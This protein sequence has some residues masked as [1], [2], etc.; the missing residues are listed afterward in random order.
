MSTNGV[1][2]DRLP[3]L[4]ELREQLNAHYR[5]GAAVPRRHAGLAPA[6]R[7]RPLALI[8][9]LILGGATGALAAAGVFQAPAVI[10]RYDRSVTPVVLRAINGSRCARRHFPATT[11]ST[12]PA[13]LLATLRVLRRPSRRG[14]T[15]DVLPSLIMPGTSL[16]VRYVRLARSVD[17]FDFYVS[18]RT[19]FAGTPLNIGRCMAAMTANFTRE[20]PRLPRAFRAEATHIFDAALG[21][22]RADWLR[23]P[24]PFVGVGLSA[25]SIYA[26]GNGFGG[27][28]STIA[29]IDEGKD[30]G[31][32]GGATGSGANTSFVDGLVPDGVS[33]L[34]LHYD[35]GP[36]GGYSRQHVPALN[37]TTRVV[38]NV[39]A[40]IVPR[41]TGNAL[42]WSITWR[43]A[44]GKLIK[45]I[46][47][48]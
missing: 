30:L 12:A 26:P 46:R 42:P 4:A 37:I 36:L 15:P 23:T 38:N 6:H 35:A 33:S 24:R 44:N 29:S 16:Y 21:V 47:Y 8:A 9:L 11:A 17:G 28:S 22:Q 34:T 43:A 48:R 1:G 32:G 20:L 13:G 2:F 39:F 41:P 40:T 10:K 3:I 45:S 27:G 25:V 18:V 5:A 7:W 31:E 14:G 19:S